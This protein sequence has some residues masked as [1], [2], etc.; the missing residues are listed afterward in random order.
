MDLVPFVAV[1]LLAGL[2]VGIVA[3]RRTYDLEER[4]R[5]RTH[6]FELRLR[7][8]EREVLPVSEPGSKPE[9][10][11]PPEP[12]PERPVVEIPSEPVPVMEERRATEE[13]APPVVAAPLERKPFPPPLPSSFARTVSLEHAVGTRWLAWVGMV[14]TLIG[15]GLFLKYMYDNAWIG[16]KGRLAIGTVAGIVALSLGERFRRKDWSVLFQTLTGGGIAAFYICIFF[17]FQVY[18][19]SG[20]GPSMALAVLVTLL[21]VVMG[22]VH[23]AVSIAVLALIGGFLSPV[24]LSAGE[25]TQSHPYQLFVYIAILDFVAMGTAYFRRWRAIDLLSFA[26]TA[27]IYQGWFMKYYRVEGEPAEMVAALVF[28]TLF[29]LMFLLIPVM[30]NLVR[31]L[32]GTVEGILL[33]AANATFSLI[34]YYNILFETQRQA[35]GF[36]V[37]GQ[38][39]VVFLVFL[40]WTRRVGMRDRMGESLLIVTLALVTLAVPIQMKLYAIPI[41]WALEGILFVYLG[42]RFRRVIPT[43]A[44]AAALL[45]AA[46]G[47]L[48]RLPLH[49]FRFVPVFN[50]PFGSWVVVIAAAGGAAYLLSR[51]KEEAGYRILSA[52]AYLLGFA[53]GCLLLTMEISRFWVLYHPKHHDIH[54]LSSLMVLWALIPAGT[55][56]VL[57]RKNVAAWMPVSLVC[58]TIGAI[59]FLAGLGWYDLPTSWLVINY[60]FPARLTFVLSLW[61]GGRLLRGR[62]PEEGSTAFT[63]VGHMFLTI[64]LAV[65][66]YRWSNH[67]EWV[68]GRM[69]MS[70]ISAV[71]AVQAFALVWF[72]LV[73]RN[74]ACRILGFALFGLT[75]AKVCLYDLSALDRVYQIISFIASGL[76]ALAAGYFYQRYSPMLLG[77]DDK[78]KPS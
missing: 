39:I 45:L 68:S 70:L 29:Y 32:S 33:V 43:Y 2:V 19:L 9:A 63:V 7:R 34:C 66:L 61:F 57:C 77:E 12:V 25:G 73:A 8:V 42:I 44:G 22:V 69:A 62:E 3:L 28:A 50:V 6:D 18:H 1:V 21:A 11:V 74:R 23:N 40:A 17:S 53:L 52:G 38:A 20:P 76:L 72:G 24:L 59:V 13:A 49:T 46:S 31:R 54:Q 71:W 60:A 56:A 78:E 26:G 67:T 55:A 51:D 64:L 5:R 30:H 41:T 47:L 4:V 37:L 35:M 36:V 10:A 65:E 27:L 58:Y 75:I 48:Y 16:P 14:L 15:V